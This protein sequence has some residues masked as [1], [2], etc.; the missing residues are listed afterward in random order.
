MKIIIADIIIRIHDTGM[1]AF[2][3]AVLLNP[4]AAVGITEGSAV[5]RS[6]EIK[7][8]KN[9]FISLKNKKCL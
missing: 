6:L 3:T 4:F 7:Y 8:E 2:E 5:K 1:P 9:V